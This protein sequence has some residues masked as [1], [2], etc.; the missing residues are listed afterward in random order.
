MQQVSDNAG[1]STGWVIGVHPVNRELINATLTAK[2]CNTIEKLRTYFG[3]L[4][5]YRAIPDVDVLLALPPEELGA[6]LLFLIRQ[7]KGDRHFH[8]G[9]LTLQLYPQHQ[10]AE[11]YPRECEREISL[12]FVEAWAWLEAQ[13]LV[14]PEPGDSGVRG[15]LSDGRAD[16]K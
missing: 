2:A 14:V 10:G 8:I 16:S 13:G 12:A 1:F 9:N 11:G 3:T 7:R 5:F 4:E 6:K 15:L